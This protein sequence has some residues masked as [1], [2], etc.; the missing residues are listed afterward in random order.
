MTKPHPVL[1][2][3]YQDDQEKQT[4]LRKIFDEAAP[5]YEG[6]AKWGWFGSGHRYRKEALLRAGL[7]EGMRVLDVAAGTGPTARAIKEIVGSEKLVT[8]LE[9]SAGMIAESRK[10]LACEHIKAGA[11]AMPVE[12]SSYDFVTMGFALRHVDDL[13]KAFAEF[14]RVLRPSGK[15][16]I[17]DVTV[18]KSWTGKFLMKAY[19][20]YTLPFLTRVFTGSKP[21]SYLMSYYWETMETMTPPETVIRAL[22]KAGFSTVTRRL[23][24]GV[25]SEYEA[26]RSAHSPT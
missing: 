19:F 11:E 6:I 1:S 24:L 22:E 18:P 13:E 21:A 2:A 12:D 5:H 26:V 4:F 14:H 9:P 3:H 17:L 23:N 20:K 7:T 25:F 15:A 16:V 10:L 8:C